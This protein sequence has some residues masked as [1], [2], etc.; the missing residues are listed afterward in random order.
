MTSLDFAA[1]R[2]Q[3][4]A[5]EDRQ[6]SSSQPL[7]PLAISDHLQHTLSWFPSG[8]H[9]PIPL[10]PQIEGVFPSSDGSGWDVVLI[11]DFV[12]ESE[13]MDL[14]ESL[15]S[16]P[17]V[18]WEKAGSRWVSNLGGIPPPTPDANEPMVSIPLPHAATQ[19]ANALDSLGCTWAEWG[20]DPNH[21][22]LNK[23]PSGCGIKAH[24]D[25]PRFAPLTASLSLGPET[26]P[27]VMKWVHATTGEEIGSVVLP[28]RS[29]V[30]FA[31]TAYTDWTHEILPV[32]TGPRYSLTLR[33]VVNVVEG[34]ELLMTSSA[35]A[36]RKRAKAMMLLSISDA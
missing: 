11:H 19:L 10:P 3:M 9:A 27:A 26:T 22:L 14:I 28:P 30:V 31:R 32:E 25:G 15:E 20:G 33:R 29:L 17:A 2:T 13:E 24:G 36:D 34:G 12:S 4:L 35:I 6:A 21:V 16:D 23:Y 7:P 8:T 18:E 5:E 1:L